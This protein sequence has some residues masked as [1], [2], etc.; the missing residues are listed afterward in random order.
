[1]Q[2]QTQKLIPL[3]ARILCGI[4]VLA[5]AFISRAQ[6]DGL[7]THVRGRIVLDVENRGEAW[8]VAPK[9]LKRYSLG[10]P[11]QAF[12]VMRTLSLGI[13]NEHL[14][15][16]PIAGQSETGTDQVLRERLAGHILLQ[17][18]GRGEAWYVYPGDL[19]RYYLGRPEDAFKVM[20]ELG[21]GITAQDLAHIPVRTPLSSVSISGVP[22]IAQAPLAEWNDIRQQEGC[23][24]ASVLMSMGWVYNQGYRPA[25]A[26]NE[27]ISMAAAQTALYGTHHDTSARDT[28]ER[29]FKQYFQYGNVE[30]HDHATVDDIV[31]HLKEGKLVLAA[32][33]GKTLHNP[34]FRQPAPDRHMI[35]V[36][37]YDAATDEFITHEPGTRNGEN[38]RYS[39]DVMR[40]SLRDYASGRYAPIPE[41]Y[42]TA[43]ITVAK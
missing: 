4:A 34:Y 29:L 26:R 12:E 15:Q 25:E 28:M 39:Y 14:A 43:I 33:N 32:V 9:G 1:M 24:E 30:V 21:L 18:E 37:G 2:T 19:H 8:Y 22:F 36:H 38:Y 3:C 23:E 6:A 31:T 27:I 11:E 17:V 35:V 16:I 13:S 10:R 40:E 42:R 7:D 41:P 20:R 5:L